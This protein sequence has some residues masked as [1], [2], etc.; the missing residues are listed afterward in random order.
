[1]FKV[2]PLKLKLLPLSIKVEPN[3]FQNRTSGAKAR[4]FDYQC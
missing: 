3:Q 4:T 2:E 1:M